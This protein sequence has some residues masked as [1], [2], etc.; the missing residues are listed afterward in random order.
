MFWLLAWIP[1]LDRDAG[2]QCNGNVQEKNVMVWGTCN[3]PTVH[4]VLAGGRN[5]YHHLHTPPRPAWSWWGKEMLKAHSY[6]RGAEKQI[7][8]KSGERQRSNYPQHKICYFLLSIIHSKKALI[9][10][11]AWWLHGRNSLLQMHQKYNMTKQLN[12][13]AKLQWNR[14]LHFFMLQTRRAFV[15]YNIS[16]LFFNF[17]IFFYFRLKYDVSIWD[18]SYGLC[19]GKA[20]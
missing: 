5:G 8:E 10:C 11:F 6:R 12:I 14:N 13:A 17:F 15:P 4:G 18:Q 16:T 2:W 3:K 19:N 20:L 7:G 1:E 9:A